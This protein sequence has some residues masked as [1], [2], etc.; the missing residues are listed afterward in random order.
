MKSSPH[1]PRGWR[2]QADPIGILKL[3]SAGNRR[4]TKTPIGRLAF[5]G[6]AG[7]ELMARATRK[8]REVE[9]DKNR[10]LDTEALPHAAITL[11]RRMLAH[12]TRRAPFP[13]A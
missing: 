13:D 9:K 5:P 7:L 8:K 12:E 4:W 11:L 3:L 1:W 6:E 10:D 2:W